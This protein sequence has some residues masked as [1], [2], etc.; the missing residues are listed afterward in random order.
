SRA[1]LGLK[2]DNV[3]TFRVS[4]GLNGYT[5]PRTLALF[6]RIEEEIGALPGVS[7]VT[8]S[9]VPVLGGSNWGSGVKVQGF[10]NGPDVDANS[11]YTFV[12]PG[13]FR[14]LG[15]PLIAGREFNRSDA[16]K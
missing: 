3:V 12:G 2:A 14:T 6:E 13:F 8:T 4:P 9:T 1:E 11:R 7:G 15:V 5:L 16:E 10:E